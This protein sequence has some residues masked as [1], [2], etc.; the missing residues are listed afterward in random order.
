M[1]ENIL[2]MLFQK[3]DV[4]L[5]TIQKEINDFKT[6]FQANLINLQN[7]VDVQEVKIKNVEN[8]L[9]KPFKEK[10]LDMVLQGF[11]YSIS[12]CLGIS[13]FFMILKGIGGDILTILKPILSAFVGI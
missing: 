3:L 1:S 7:K 5:D 10:L 11:V 2:E 12:V 9:S 13:I 4:K 8:V 6:G